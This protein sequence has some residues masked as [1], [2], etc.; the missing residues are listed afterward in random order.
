[1][2]SA[3]KGPYAGCMMSYSEVIPGGRRLRCQD[4][5]LSRAARIRLEWFQFYETHDRNARL[6][7]T[8]GHTL[9]QFVWT[10]PSGTPRQTAYAPDGLLKQ[11]L[12]VHLARME[13]Y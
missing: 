2:S 5:E 1:M 13:S 12:Q 8:F 10:I 7:S 9:V 11:V 6:T 3:G 4:V